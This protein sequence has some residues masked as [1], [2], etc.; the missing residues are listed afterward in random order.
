MD[1]KV[2]ARKPILTSWNQ[3]RH[4]E[5]YVFKELVSLES[6]YVKSYLICLPSWKTL[7]YVQS[8]IK[9]TWVISKDIG[10]LELSFQ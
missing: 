10:W 3:N 4:P 7:L 9:E 6:L 8:H 2:D 1:N 5:D